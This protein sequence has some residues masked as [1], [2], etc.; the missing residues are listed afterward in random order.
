MTLYYITLPGA[1]AARASLAPSVM[2]WHYITLYYITLPGAA[3]ARASRPPS[4]RP[5][6]ARRARVTGWFE[7]PPLN[8]S[9]LTAPSERPPLRGGEKASVDLVRL[10]RHTARISTT[11]PAII[12]RTIG[13]RRAGGAEPCRARRSAPVPSLLAGRGGERSSIA[14]PDLALTSFIQYVAPP[15]RPCRFDRH[16]AERDGALA[17]RVLPFHSMPL[18]LHR[19]VRSLPCRARRSTRP[20]CPYIP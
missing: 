2:P 12:T 7:R 10:T 17:P 11:P 3:A 5:T 14:F 16:L 18:L 19:A 4:G 6:P 1:A 20:T 8:G 15:L 9:L 13:R